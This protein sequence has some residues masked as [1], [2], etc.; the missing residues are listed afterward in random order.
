MGLPKDYLTRQM[1]LGLPCVN[2][3][4]RT[5]ICR[6]KN[7][8]RP[9]FGWVECTDGCGYADTFQNFVSA[10]TDKKKASLK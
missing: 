5:L 9:P 8:N 1:K 7:K 10:Y 6:T 2:C 4:S 3:D